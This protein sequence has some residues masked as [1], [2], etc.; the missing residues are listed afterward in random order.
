VAVARSRADAIAKA[1]GVLL[2][3]PMRV[4]EGESMS[5]P[6]RPMGMMKMAMAQEATPTEVSAGEIEI[7][8]HVR[9][10][11]SIA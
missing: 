4:E 7:T 10:W 3:E 11:F 8:A 6:I 5:G 2:G 9:V 1:A